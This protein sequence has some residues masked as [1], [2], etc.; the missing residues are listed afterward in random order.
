[1]RRLHGITGE[2][3][4]LCQRCGVHYPMSGL[5]KQRTEAGTELMVCVENCFDR[6]DNH[7]REMQIAQA[8]GSNAGIENVDHRT[9]DWGW[10]ADA[11]ENF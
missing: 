7:H 1:M 8:L 6:T 5:T 2:Q 11:G 10:F 4:D 9:E 3:H